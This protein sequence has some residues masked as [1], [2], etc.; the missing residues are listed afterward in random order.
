MDVLASDS[1]F[2]TDPTVINNQL[3]A[4]GAA[5]QTVE[6]SNN[7]VKTYTTDANGVVDHSADA[8]DSSVW[9]VTCWVVGGI[10]LLVVT[11]AVVLYFK[12]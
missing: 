2:P 10:V 9:I 4:T 3:P 11:I 8:H 12:R 5:P 7:V 1:S 6:P